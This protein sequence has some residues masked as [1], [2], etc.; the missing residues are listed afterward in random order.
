MKKAVSLLQDELVAIR[1]IQSLQLDVKKLQQHQAVMQWLSQTDFAARQHD[2]ISRKVEGTGQS[3]LDSAEFKAWRQGL[4]L[5]LFCP[6]IPG[7]G[8]TLMAAI[9]IDYLCKRAENEDIG[10]AYIFCTYKEQLGQTS[11]TLLAVI[12]KQLLQSRPDIA[13]PITKMYDIHQKHQSR[14]SNSEILSALQLVCSAY[15]FTYI[16]LDALDECTDQNGTR[17][18]LIDNLREL[19]KRANVRLMFTSRFNPEIEEKFTSDCKL[20]VRASNHDIRQYVASQLPYFPKCIQR[21][22]D[23]MQDVQ[24]KIAIASDGMYV[25]TRGMKHSIR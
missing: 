6:G 9:T 22:N 20:E 19:Q 25:H 5:T 2:I 7:A 11:V 17:G 14:P 18:R 13:G 1:D 15:S 10:V 24:D 3:F 4:A 21:C 23:L 12:L 16:I 8:K